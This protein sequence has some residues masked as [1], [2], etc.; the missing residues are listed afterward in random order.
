MTAPSTGKFSLTDKVYSQIKEMIVYGQLRPG[1]ALNVGEIADRFHVSKTPVR[2]AFNFLKHDGLIEILPYKGCLVSQVNLKDL[3]ELFT[4]RVLLEGAAA[5]LAATHANEQ[6]LRKLEALINTDA[7]QSQPTD[8]VQIMKLNF[9][10]HVAIAEASNNLRLKKMVINILDTMQRVLYLD[11]KIGSS[12]SMNDHI[13]LVELIKRKDA[14]G[15]KK[16]MIDHVSS[17]RNRIF[18]T[19]FI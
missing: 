9:E 16:L 3:G 18:S 12:Y 19:D 11:L 15:A 8:E 13:Q 7:Q 4:L 6:T 10:F 5:E 1:E 17:T 14:T 2:E